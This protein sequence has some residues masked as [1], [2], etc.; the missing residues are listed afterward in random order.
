MGRPA[1]KDS[2]TP[3]MA[4][5]PSAVPSRFGRAIFAAFI[6]AVLTA[7]GGLWW[8]CT[9]NEGIAFLPAHAGGEWI[10]FPSQAQ[11]KPH[12]VASVTV[13]FRHSFTLNAQPADATLVVCAFKGATVALNGRTLSNTPCTG[14]NWKLPS[15]AGVASLLQPGTNV[16]TAWVTNA[17]GPPAL[18]LALKSPPFSLGTSEAWQVSL[19]GTQWQN[20]RR[21]RQPIEFQADGSLQGS[22]RMMDLLK[23][24]WPVEAV[25][26]AVSLALVW[27]INR[28]LRHKRLPAGTLPARTSAK[29]IYGLLVIVLMAQTAL[30][31]NDFRQI[32]RV[33]GFDAVAHE[34]YV[35]FIQQRHTLPLANDGWQMFQPPLYYLASTLLLES[36]GRSVGDDDAVYFLRAVNGVVCLVHCWVVLLCLRLLLPGNL[37]AQAAGLLVAAFLP[38]NLYLSQYVTNEPLA[39]FLV[40]VAIYCCLRAL[41]AEREG[42]WL[43]IGIGA[44]LGAAM[45]TKFS[46]LLALPLFALV[47]SQRLAARKAGAWRHWLRSMGAVVVGCLLV[48]GWHY[49]RVWAR[50]GK[51]IVMNQGDTE[52]WHAWWQDPGFRTSAFYTSFGQALTSPSF[53]AFHSFADGIY[54]TLWGDGLVSGVADRNF[55]PPWNYDLMG[56]GYW[57]SLGVSLLLITGA[58]LTLVR[59]TG[60]IRAEW[61]LILGMVFA[62]GFGLLWNSLQAPYYC[63]VKAFYAFPALLPFSAL[64]AVGC[65]WLRQR[66]RA[67]GLAVWVLLL[68]WA[69]TAYTSFWIRRENPEAQFLKG[70][71]YNNLGVELGK[72]GR[73]EEAIRQFQEALRLKP[74]FTDACCNLG[75]ARAKKGQFDEAIRQYQEA[76]RLNPN[77][78]NAHYNLGLAFDKKGQSDEAIRQFRETLRLKPDHADARKDLNAALASKANPLQQSGTSTNR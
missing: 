21:A 44:A 68:V 35:Q 75:L 38:P 48:C 33:M 31:I 54:S 2:H 56:A 59:L 63:T 27:G 58:A 67:M 6:L 7:A 55:Q 37:P 3:A 78:A 12:D 57:I 77:H 34:E 8:M 30:F 52:L 1:M 16:I 32:P 20:A 13:A 64:V 66:Y 11:S 28:W 46:V 40:T 18:W 76:I 53:S 41:R 26:C 69:M 19:N 45:L 36:C 15:N 60:Q 14:R 74:D 47:L 23:R 71:E 65:D 5:A 73:L 29:L 62:F 22:R 24:V 10:V 72:E 25:F 70:I 17:V 61:L 42:F 39:G 43:P 51:P 49:G 4:S 9:R 50:F